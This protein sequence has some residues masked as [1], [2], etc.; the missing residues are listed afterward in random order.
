MHH[1]DGDTGRTSKNEERRQLAVL[2]PRLPA[3]LR[4]IFAQATAIHPVAPVPVCFT[5]HV[6][7]APPFRFR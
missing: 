6:L 5:H 1:R 2:S 3:V 4:S 7:P